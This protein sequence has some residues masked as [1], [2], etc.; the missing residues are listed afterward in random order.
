MNKKYNWWLWFKF[1]PLL[2]MLLPQESLSAEKMS[3]L[4]PADSILPMFFGLL[5]ILAIIFGLAFVFKKVTNFS[6]NSGKIKVLESQI[7]GNKEKLIVVEVGDQQFFLGVTNQNITALGELKQDNKLGQK[8][9]E[10]QPGFSNLFSQML[11]GKV[12]HLKQSNSNSSSSNRDSSV[13]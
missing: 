3:H 2:L 8:N 9:I 6:S 1:L 7:I 4:T 10:K 5:V 11:S 13:K 12:V